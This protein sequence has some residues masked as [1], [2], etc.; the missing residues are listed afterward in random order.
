MK[1][2]DFGRILGELKLVLILIPVIAMLT[3]AVISMFI[4][5]PVYES[6]TTITVLRD[7]LAP[8]SEININTIAINQRLVRTYSE[9][10]KSRSVA[11]DVIKSNNLNL[12]PLELGEK[13]Q[14][15][16]AGDTEVLIISA[17]DANPSIAALI[18]NGVAQSL[19][20]KVQKIL[21]VKN[22]QVLDQAIPPEKPVSPNVLL[23]V[24]LAGIL[25]LFTTVAI[26]FVREY[27][28]D[29]IR[30]SEEVEDFLKL[31]VLGLIP[32]AGIR[33]SRGGGVEIE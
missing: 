17:R 7:Q 22:I 29:T 6:T 31:P 9:L 13:I 27:V 15:E 20:G 19:S 16:L 30:N 8:F 33:T 2:K 3:S 23:N 12:T 4:L 25:G 26:I 32:Y 14:V 24:L 1:L 28:D 11:E 5:T 10:A 21:N 18:A